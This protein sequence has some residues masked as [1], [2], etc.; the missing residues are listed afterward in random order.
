MDLIKNG[1][2]ADVYLQ[3]NKSKSDIDQI[4]IERQ[5]K[6][7]LQTMLYLVAL[8]RMLATNKGMTTA[9]GAQWIKS[10][11][12]VR[13]NVVKRPLS[14]GKGTIKRSEGTKGSKCPKCKEAKFI[15]EKGAG[16]VGC[17]VK[18]PKCNG[19]G[20][21]GGKPPESEA[22]FY[23]RVKAY[24][25]AEPEVYFARF[26]VEVSEKDVET[27]ER[28]CLRPILEQL[29]EWYELAAAPNCEEVGGIW[30]HR[31]HWRHPFGVYNVLNEGGSSDLDDY[32]TTGSEVGLRRVDKLF[33]ELE[34]EA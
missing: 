20:R 30:S 21:I 9:V 1:A 22:D 4:A 29:C 19:A 26:K 23:N 25:V 7:D 31:N 15:I 18:C 16:G 8:N 6:F 14:G 17:K 28:T 32:L 11:A 3:E 5:L 33:E 34:E 12:G 10:A 2:G 24:I 27:F 13:Y